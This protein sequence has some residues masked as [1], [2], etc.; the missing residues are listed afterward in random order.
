MVCKNT[1]AIPCGLCLLILLFSLFAKS[2][3]EI[4]TAPL[5]HKPGEWQQW[6]GPDGLGVSNEKNLPEVWSYNSSNIR[7]KTTIPGE[8]ISS[9][10]ISHGRIFLTTAYESSKGSLVYKFVLVTT[11]LMV[12]G[13]LVI[14][15]ILF[16]EKKD[17][18]PGP[19]LPKKKK[20]S[21]RA[22]FE[23]FFVGAATF[24]FLV[25]AVLVT[26]GEKYINFSLGKISY[27]LWQ[28]GFSEIGNLLRWNRGDLTRIWLI[29]GGIA[30]LGVTA[31]VG[32]FNYRSISR[33]LGASLTF[34]SV[35][36]F[37]YFIPE[38]SSNPVVLWKRLFFALPG[39]TVAF[40][41]VLSF[42]RSRRDEKSSNFLSRLS[43]LNVAALSSLSALIF[44]SANFLPQQFGLH[45][46]AICLDLKSGKT[47]WERLVFLAP[48]ER[49]NLHNSYATPTPCTDGK[50]VIVYF[51]SG[52]VCL[53]FDGNE[54]WKHEY[55][56]YAPN[57]RYGVGASP[58]IMDDSVILVQDRERSGKQASS[59][60]TA[61]QIQSGQI[62]WQVNRDYALNSYSTPITIRQ[63]NTMQ[64]ITST[65]AAI[66]AHDIYSG[67]RLWIQEHPVH[68]I[69]SSLVRSGEL[70]C[71]AGGMYNPKAIIVMR[72][73]STTNHKPEVLWE[74]NQGVPS[75]SSP[76]IYNGKLFVVTDTGIMTC[77][78]MAS[79]KEH[80]K[81][82]LKSGRYY[83]SLVSGD[84][85][86]YALNDKG[87]TTVVAADSVLRVISENDLG[88]GSYA[89]PAIADGCILIRAEHS[90]FCIDNERR[91]N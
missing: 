67:E 54:L 61:F 17:D 8:G 81:T 30:L 33:L 15:F 57:T 53:D 26:L 64:L 43:L 37:V 25:L 42:I 14:S 38:L 32:W 88:E 28:I 70:L 79:G 21:A 46:V 9:P 85:K 80:W 55:P 13:I 87:V 4:K 65:D 27:L 2:A 91:S 34:L 69:V 51:G 75:I 47:T 16:V 72:L 45:R 40:W 48:A 78:D 58:L 11:L 63:N 52:I 29:S 62:K 49:K 66:V 39:L 50:Y 22:I 5:D 76:L 82:R 7:W 6:R 12:V 89:S 74:S 84:D 31:S 71:F 60:I 68:Q 56:D 86:V 35:A 44:I 59:L 77:Y 3:G 36:P 20:E 24:C 23:K 10:I 73:H 18:G 19:E 83:S 90:L 1:I 41:Y